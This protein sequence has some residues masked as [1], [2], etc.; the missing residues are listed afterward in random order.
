VRH[1]NITAH[2]TAQWT[3]QQVV[4]DEFHVTHLLVDL[5]VFGPHTPQYFLP[6]TAE[7]SAAR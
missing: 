7:V 2:P 5:N 4:H 6:F 1:F 3:A